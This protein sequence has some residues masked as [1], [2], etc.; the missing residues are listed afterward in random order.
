MLGLPVALVGAMDAGSML[1]ALSMHSLDGYS[2]S[3]RALVRPLDR[4]SSVYTV[5]L[6]LLLAGAMRAAEPLVLGA[7]P[8]STCV[9]LVDVVLAGTVLAAVLAALSTEVHQE[10]LVAVLAGHSVCHS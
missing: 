10:G 1:L 4:V 2:R 6:S 8:L 7:V 9:G 3:G 5:L